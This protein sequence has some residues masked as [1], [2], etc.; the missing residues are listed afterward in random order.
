VCAA[1]YKLTFD[2]TSLEFVSQTAGNFLSQDGADTIEAVNVLNSESQKLEYGE[3][4]RGV[5]TGVMA[6]GTL[7]HITF[8]VI[9]GQGSYLDLTEV[10]VGAPTDEG[11]CALPVSVE[12]GICLVDGIAPTSTPEP[13][14]TV[15]AWETP[16]PTATMIET[17]I[18]TPEPELVP[19]ET[20][21]YESTPPLEQPAGNPESA[22]DSTPA[23]HASGFGVI[24]ACAGILIVLFVLKRRR[25]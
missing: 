1:Q 20:S 3:A 14:T 11:S 22:H 19:E 16:A 10:V 8:R 25:Y 12:N 9:G 6:T 18:P 17:A 24:A 4:R 23:E 2:T 15:T 5:D 7:A 13:T 21:T